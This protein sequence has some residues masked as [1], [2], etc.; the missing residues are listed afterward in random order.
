[1]SLKYEAVVK[2]DVDMGQDRKGFRNLASTW[3]FMVMVIG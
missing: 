3:F 1:V 2:E